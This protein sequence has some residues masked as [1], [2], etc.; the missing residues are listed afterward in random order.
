MR[1]GRQ[2]GGD[3]AGRGRREKRAAGEK[4]QELAA[5][6]RVA[7]R[8]FRRFTIYLGHEYLHCDAE[9]NRLSAESEKY[10]ERLGDCLSRQVHCSEARLRYFGASCSGVRPRSRTN[11][12][13]FQQNQIERAFDP[14]RIDALIVPDPSGTNRSTDVSSQTLAQI[15]HASFGMLDDAV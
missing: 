11:F 3:G 14:L 1:A 10:S 15:L 7:L 9:D 12:G 8:N 4:A 2:Q 6:D 13:K 5:R